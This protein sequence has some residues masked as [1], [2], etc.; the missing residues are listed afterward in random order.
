MPSTVIRSF[1]YDDARRELRIRFQSGRRYVYLDVPPEM[2]DRMK[3]SFSKG[4]FFNQHIR[5]QFRFVRDPEAE[6]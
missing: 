4:E 5:N 2:F 1:A 3:G 6:S